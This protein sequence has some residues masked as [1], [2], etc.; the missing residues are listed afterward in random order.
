MREHIYPREHE[1]EEFTLDSENSWQQPDWFDDLREK[2]KAAGPWNLF[3][4][5]KDEPWSPML[6]N[7]EGQSNLEYRSDT[8]A[9]GPGEDAYVILTSARTGPCI[10]PFEKTTSWPPEIT[11]ETGFERRQQA[12]IR[13]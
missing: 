7:L 12:R 5:K 13:P 2:V 9:E 4:P 8:P 3:L 11:P 10:C 1:Y 6:T